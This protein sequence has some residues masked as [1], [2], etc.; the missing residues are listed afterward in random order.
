MSN[1]AAQ[2][3]PA[4]LERAP[5]YADLDAARGMLMALGVVIHT[6]NIYSP[7][8]SDVIP[9]PDGGA[10]FTYI[11]EAMHLFRMPAF[12]LISGF[13]CAMSLHKY[14]AGKVLRVRALRL[15][16]PLVTTV[17]TFNVGAL[18]LLARAG[19]VSLG[20]PLSA[21]NALA[22]FATVNWLLHL[23]FLV[24]LFAF[25]AISALLFAVAR[26]KPPSISAS[27]RSIDPLYLA[28][29]FALLSYGAP[30]FGAI[31]SSVVYTP[32]VG[33]LTV[34]TF[35]EYA[36]YFI[37]GYYLF[38]RPEMM[39][40]LRRY[41]NA[42]AM[43]FLAVVLFWPV[44]KITRLLPDALELGFAALGSWV[45]TL[46]AFPVFV[47]LVD[48]LQFDA[49]ALARASYTFYL[50]HFVLVTAYSTLVVRVSA[51]AGVEFSFIVAATLA[52]TLLFHFYV[53][54]KSSILSLSLNGRHI[55]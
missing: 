50:A 53:V 32:R 41:S 40:K 19:V 43:L 51:P 15:L 39:S 54:Q 48:R 26:K 47:A 34:Y 16:L 8:A 38:S 2:I 46:T 21:G 1:T 30:A 14:G 5:Y 13:F 44:E 9:D 24:V 12:F 29:V 17:L 3:S 10:A 11:V 22:E 27:F 52:L 25:V 36:P 35:L 45:A 55:R 42:K 49:R 18:W 31:A 28:P 6:A 4:V 37:V 7:G 23:W 33:A 20:P